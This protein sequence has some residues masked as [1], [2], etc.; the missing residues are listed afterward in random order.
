ME[1]LK[2][3]SQQGVLVV[4]A[5]IIVTI[6]MI[7]ITVMLYL[8]LIMYH[9]TMI[10]AMANRTATD[11]AQ[12]YSNNLKDPF[13]GYVD[14]DRVYKSVTYS[15]MKDDAYLQ[16]M[17]EKASVLARYRL[18]S[19]RLLADKSTEV[20]VD[21][22]KKPKEIF[23]NQ[24]VVK[25]NSQYNVPLVSF[26]DVQGSMQFSA[27]G[28]AD[29][30]DVLEYVN[31]VNVVGNPEDS[32]VQVLPDM[33]SS[34]V[35]F[36]VDKHTGGFHAAV[37]VITKKSIITSNRDSHSEMP[38]DPQLNGMKFTGWV[39]DSGMNFTAS[40][41]VNSDITVYGSWECKITFNPTGG[42]VSPASKVVEYYKTTSF[43]TPTRSG[44]AFEGWFTEPEGKGTQYISNS[45]IITGNITL[46]AKWRCTHDYNITQIRSAT[47][48][49]KSLFKYSCI[50]CPYTFEKVGNTVPCKENTTPIVINATCSAAGSK[51]Y[52]C[53]Y[54]NRVMRTVI[55]DKLPHKPDG[56]TVTKQPTCVAKG[57]KVI[58]CKV[59][60]TVLE[61]I[62]LKESGHTSDYGTVIKAPTCT[63]K[64]TKVYNC[65]VCGKELKRESIN[66]LGHNMVYY[67]KAP[68]C[69]E[70]GYEGEKCTRCD[71]KKGNNVKALGHDWD[72]RCGY[73]HPLGK[74]TIKIKSHNKKAGY[75]YSTKAECYLCTRCCAP[76]G[77]KWVTRNGQKMSSGVICREHV[78]QGSSRKY[79]DSA[80]MD[81]KNMGLHKAP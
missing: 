27:T 32:P 41:I 20:E 19:A 39:T 78:N 4:E 62:A 2:K 50:R 5:S 3:S 36:I 33:N 66:K 74:D 43:P 11:I 7:I 60:R 46:Y 17:D 24:V 70:K 29:C 80:Y 69:T 51:T 21:I 30:I 9:Q 40:T 37:P 59:C 31:K 47:C 12:V 8:G 6:V 16:V 73:A 26:F 57:E 81:N 75:S 67:Y 65:K 54:C 64:G 45:T 61:R 18:R 76:Y 10:T 42:T 14:P 23:K 58:K 56:G 44:Y 52:K 55:L 49:V 79:S 34:V 38:V 35:T 63:A 48:K 15:N 53:V 28:R 71:H 1:R 13:T 77:D 25:I 68:T 22:V 72:G